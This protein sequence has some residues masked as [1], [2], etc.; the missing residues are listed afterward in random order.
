MI[1]ILISLTFSYWSAT[2]LPTQSMSLWSVSQA[3]TPAARDGPAV[4]CC[5][6]SSSSWTG[7]TVRCA[8]C[9]ISFSVW[10]WYPGNPR[11]SSIH[12]LP[13]LGV[14][15][16]L[17]V[18]TCQSCS[19]SQNPQI[20]RGQGLGSLLSSEVYTMCSS[21]LLEALVSMPQPS[22]IWHV[23]ALNPPYHPS[24]QP[25]CLNE[26]F[27]R[28]HHL[29]LICPGFYYSYQGRMRIVSDIMYI[30]SCYET[31]VMHGRLSPVYSG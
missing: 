1:C 20:H 5:S 28:I 29:L 23:V 15:P 3:S 17:P 30:T 10:W 11:S 4:R 18:T 2:G 31:A 25:P 14:V 13:L 12:W 8:S 19:W 22:K 16:V 9:A 26:V 24:H 21:V 7:V 27:Y 6:F